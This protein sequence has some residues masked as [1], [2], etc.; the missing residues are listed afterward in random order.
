MPPHLERPVPRRP[1]LAV[2]APDPKQKDQTQ[3]PD[4]KDEPYDPDYDN[5]DGGSPP[6]AKRP[7]Q[8]RL[9]PIEVVN[10]VEP[11]LQRIQRQGFST[12]RRTK[13]AGTRPQTP[14]TYGDDDGDRDGEG[15]SKKTKT[16]VNANPDEPMFEDQET[17]A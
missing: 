14:G 9:P 17:Y 1:N 2:H 4:I 12:E 10:L 16:P 8:P 7:G 15:G 11:E 3:D 13:A 5:T 6:K